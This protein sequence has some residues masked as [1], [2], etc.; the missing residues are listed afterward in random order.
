M[1]VVAASTDL[2]DRSRIAATVP[3]VMLVRSLAGVEAD[4]V[5][6]DVSRPALV[7]ELRGVRAARIVAYA[8]HVDDAA[9]GAALAAGCTEV[10]ARSVFFRRLPHLVAGRH[11][12]EL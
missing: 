7:A 4:V 1:R 10:L 6:V 9:Q 12:L 5:L 2:L 11:P 8:P 3:G